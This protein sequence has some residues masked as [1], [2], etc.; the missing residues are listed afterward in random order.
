MYAKGG[1]IAGGLIA[2]GLIAGGAYNRGFSCSMQKNPPDVC[3]AVV[4][5]SRT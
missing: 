3:W 2:G 5:P 4:I 1:L